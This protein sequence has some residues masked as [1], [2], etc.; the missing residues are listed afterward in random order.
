MVQE[1]LLE[2][3]RVGDDVQKVSGEE[4]HRGAGPV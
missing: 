1:G 3:S 4:R 2:A